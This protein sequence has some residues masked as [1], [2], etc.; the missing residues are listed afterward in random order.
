MPDSSDKSNYKLQ[1]TLPC[2]F[3]CRFVRGIGVMQPTCKKLLTS[4]GPH[5]PIFV[6]ALGKCDA[7]AI[8]RRIISQRKNHFGR[9]DRIL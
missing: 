8:E 1:N 5:S 7:F 6:D 3:N 2:C 9:D 4:K